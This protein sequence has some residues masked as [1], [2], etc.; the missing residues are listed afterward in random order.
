MA[1]FMQGCQAE[2]HE[3]MKNLAVDLMA[4]PW[5]NSDIE[6]FNPLDPLIVSLYQD[7]RS[8]LQPRLQSLEK[9]GVQVFAPTQ[10][11]SKDR[12]NFHQEYVRRCLNPN[13]VKVLF[14]G[15]NPGPEGMGRNG[16]PFGDPE[17]VN[18]I[19]EIEV[20][21]RKHDNGKPVQEPSG[22]RLWK[23]LKES[24]GAP[25]GSP[26]STRDKIFKNC[27]VQNVCPIL[28]TKD[29]R[30]VTPF[31][32]KELPDK[33]I[34]D[35]IKR[36]CEEALADVIELLQLKVI[37][38]IGRDAEKRAKAAIKKYSRGDTKVDIVYMTH[39]SPESR[40]AKDE[41]WMTIAREQL[42]APRKGGMKSVM[43]IMNSM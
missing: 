36:L 4:L 10:P 23:L 12:Y 8:L 14:L 11:G 1:S 41:D 29:K 27:F 31:D 3:I 35:K 25:D 5:D 9:S 30:N 39:P 40:I 21:V 6:R 38:A 2:Y 20:P 26:H 34:R 18:L 7:V 24:V 15:L 16:I 22:R 42:S 37:V 43:D 13:G 28:F 17:S 32:S 19:L 33:E